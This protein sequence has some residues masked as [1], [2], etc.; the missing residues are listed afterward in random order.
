M[1]ANDGKWHS[2]DRLKRE[3][4]A[5]MLFYG[6]DLVS[7]NIK[8]P[9]TDHVCSLRNPMGVQQSLRLLRRIKIARFEMQ[10]FTDPHGVPLI[11][12]EE[13]QYS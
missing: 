11:Q 4:Y 7:S 2:D 10:F 8:E 12:K 1:I 5:E 9:T 3:S 13:N 6:L